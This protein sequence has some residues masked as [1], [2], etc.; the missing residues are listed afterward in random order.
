LEEA[1]ERREFPEP[2]VVPKGELVEVGLKVVP[3]HTPLVRAAEP[4]LEIGE[5][6]MDE[7]QSATRTT[8]LPVQDQVVLVSELGDTTCCGLF[9]QPEKHDSSYYAPFCAPRSAF[10]W[11]DPAAEVKAVV[12]RAIHNI[13]IIRGSAG[14]E[15]TTRTHAIA[16]ESPGLLR[17]Y[18]IRP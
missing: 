16:A 18:E 2:P 11:G 10:T 5:L 3:L 13:S 8:G 15:R 12:R 17:S 9:A 1:L 4:G 14:A 7:G 6:P